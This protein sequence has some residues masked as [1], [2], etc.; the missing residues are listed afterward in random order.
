M[1]T[2]LNEIKDQAR[3]KRLEYVLGF[4]ISFRQT[5]IKMSLVITLVGGMDVGLD[6]P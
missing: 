6:S 4:L 2:Y 1:I 3:P 5:M